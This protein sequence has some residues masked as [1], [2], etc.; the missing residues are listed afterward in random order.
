MQ[1]TW[2][3]MKCEVNIVQIRKNQNLSLSGSTNALY[4]ILGKALNLFKANAQISQISS[5]IM[6]I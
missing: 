2:I 1:S 5:N 3:Q 6:K 4:V